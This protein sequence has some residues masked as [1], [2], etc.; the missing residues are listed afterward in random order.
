MTEDW[1]RPVVAFQIVAKDSTKQREFYSELFNWPMDEG[2]IIRIAPG[3]GG[4]VEGV[5]GVLVQ[6]ETP[7]ITVFIQVRDLGAAIEKAKNMGAEMV[8]PPFDVP[9]GPTIAQ[10]RDPEGS[11][12]G[13]VQQ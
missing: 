2:P 13:L 12:L 6:G 7:S 4:P 9:N 10:I 3:V 11:L 1:S 8:M 5:G